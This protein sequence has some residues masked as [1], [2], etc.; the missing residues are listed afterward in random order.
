MLLEQE[1]M[2]MDI[3]DSLLPVAQAVSGSGDE[4]D[5]TEE[6]VNDE[7]IEGTNNL[8]PRFRFDAE[9]SAQRTQNGLCTKCGETQTHYK[10]GDDWWLSE[11]IPREH[12]RD[13]DGKP[14]V[15]KGFCLK[16]GCYTLDEAKQQLGE[17]DIIVEPSA[18][19]AHVGEPTLESPALESSS[20]IGQPHED[21]LQSGSS[22][23]SDVEKA[24]KT[25]L[26]RNEDDVS[27]V[28]HA[29]RPEIAS[30]RKEEFNA[31]IAMM[32]IGRGMAARAQREPEQQ[33]QNI[34][35]P[36]PPTLTPPPT[37][38]QRAPGHAD[39]RSFP[40]HHA[41]QATA[42]VP[43]FAT[44]TRM[45]EPIMATLHTDTQHHVSPHRQMRRQQDGFHC[46]G[47]ENDDDRIAW[48]HTNRLVLEQIIQESISNMCVPAVKVEK[49]D[50]PDRP[51]N[52][53]GK[54]SIIGDFLNPL[55]RI[56]SKD[57]GTS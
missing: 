19:R 4:S 27:T 13:C 9:Q 23:A 45:S 53:K 33:T 11:W 44:R 6:E 20:S 30:E 2:M 25:H 38:Y 41:Y 35:P 39:R 3:R 48:G 8:T 24:S 22:T 18:L 26:Q 40:G 21:V 49:V 16:P 17:F 56:K 43:A 52:A 51:K 50:P 5:H 37:P 42:A 10:S 1:D 29:N 36:A 7:E 54:K 47:E 32:N 34:A 12:A 57:P 28:I 15:Y 14:L 55:R 46:T 31:A